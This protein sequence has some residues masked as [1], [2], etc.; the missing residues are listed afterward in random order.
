MAQMFKMMNG[1]RIAVGM[2]GVGV[3]SSAFLNALE[4]A[5][6]RKQGASIEQWKDA[7]A[8]RV[9]ILQHA[10]VRRMLLDMK[11]RVEGIP[12]PRHQARPP[13]GLPERPAPRPTSAPGSIQ[14][15]PGRD[16]L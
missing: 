1:A 11:A 3:A 4:Y 8:P 9:A 5:R 2:Q 12:L 14:P 15:G 10:D 16:L 13:P 7:T 6:E